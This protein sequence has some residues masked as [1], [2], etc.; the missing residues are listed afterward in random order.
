VER[1]VE[2]RPINRLTQTF[3][4][5]EP[6]GEPSQDIGDCLD[7]DV[8]LVAGQ[9]DCLSAVVA[10]DHTPRGHPAVAAVLVP[11]PVAKL[12]RGAFAACD[13]DV[14]PEFVDVVGMNSLEPVVHSVAQ[15]VVLQA[16][17]RNPLRG[18]MNPIGFE[19]PVPQTFAVAANWPARGV[20]SVRAMFI[21]TEPAGRRACAIH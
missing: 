11:Q 15:F 2:T 8:R 13:V 3:Y 21:Q 9:T 4:E 12:E 5:Q 20:A 14:T 7:G 17:E 19:I 1:A 16:G 18:K 10:H 6:V